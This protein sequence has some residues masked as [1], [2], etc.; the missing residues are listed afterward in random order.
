MLAR[1]L[2]VLTLVLLLS[3]CG[4][5]PPPAETKAPPKAKPADPPPEKAKPLPPPPVWSGVV[6]RP[7]FG[8]PGADNAKIKNGTGFAI[9]DSKRRPYLVTCAHLLDPPQWKSLTRLEIQSLKGEML[10]SCSLKPVYIGKEMFESNRPGYVLDSSQDI[11]I[12]PLKKGCRVRPLPL[13]AQDPKFGDVVWFVGREFKRKEGNEALYAATVEIVDK[14]NF[15]IKKF[16]KLIMPGFSGSPIVNTSGAVVGILT[17]GVE[18]EDN[19]MD[20]LICGSTVR[21]LKQHLR[22]S[23]VPID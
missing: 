21:A 15:Q 14:G 5:Q 13:A 7:T 19:S 9:I 22:D 4:E 23:E 10:G 16:D 1:S 2:L 3:A 17:G 18:V 8:F 6:L 12:Y 11:A 20:N